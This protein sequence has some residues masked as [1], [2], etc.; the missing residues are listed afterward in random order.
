MY[1]F[2][3]GLGWALYYSSHTILADLK[4]KQ[5]LYRKMGGISVW[6]RLLYSL[7]SAVGLLLLLYWTSL[8]TNRI[9]E[10]VGW[11]WIA[12]VLLI[13]LG[14][15]IMYLSVRK[16]SLTEFLGFRGEEAKEAGAS[17]E[18]L[19]RHGIYSYVRHPLYLGTLGLIIGVFLLIPS[20]AFGIFIICT[21]VYLPIG[22]YFEERKLRGEFGD[23]YRNYQR[24]VKKLIPWIY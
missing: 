2:L 3:L 14:G 16:F 21:L 18:G 1:Y 15:W 13:G 23:D 8:D 24:E 5:V 10:T 22:M 11:E 19:V 4:V 12:G 9:W 6:Y 17:S 20:W 7:F